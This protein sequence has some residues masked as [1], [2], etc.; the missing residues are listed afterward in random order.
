MYLKER[1]TPYLSLLDAGQCMHLISQVT[2]FMNKPL[3][4]RDSEKS[5]GFA[6]LGE[7]MSLPID[8]NTDIMNVS[9]LFCLK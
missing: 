5:L 2:T 4:L 6:V 3:I 8:V 1:E 9:F 7:R